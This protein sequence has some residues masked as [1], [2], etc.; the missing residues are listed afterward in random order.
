MKQTPQ[1]TLI[2]NPLAGPANLAAPIAL[3]ADFWRARGW[4]VTITPT[5]A[6]GHAT[7]IARDAAAAGHRLVLAA[8]GDGTLGEVA[9][10]LAGTDAILAPLPIGT[11]NSFAKELGM[12]RPGMFER[13]RLLQTAVSLSAGRVQQMDLGFMDEGDGN[14][15]YW[16][17]W[18]GTGIDGY[19]VHKIEPRPVWSKKLGPFGYLI[20]GLAAAP[21]FPHLNAT[22]TIDGQ[23]YEGEMLLVIVSNCRMYGGEVI[24]SPN[25]VLDDGQFE[26]WMFHGHGVPKIF[27]YMFKLKQGRHLLDKNITMV[28]GQE[29]TIETDPPM[30]CH[31]DGDKAEVTPLHCRVVP[32]ALRVLVPDTT[33]TSMFSAPGAPL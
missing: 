24:L 25:A 12:P 14:G 20:Q 13:H 3:V 22:V 10:G 30:G 19:L 11:A 28:R 33:A 31:T 23:I 1:A 5:E 4:D 18:S 2:Y 29:I 16:L 6:E 32:R 27:D 21:Q 9:N 15:R 8:G 7:I 17:L 26:V